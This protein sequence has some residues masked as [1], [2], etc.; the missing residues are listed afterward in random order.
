MRKPTQSDSARS[1]NPIPSP[2]SSVSHKTGASQA[3]AGSHT[4]NPHQ[5]IGNGGAQQPSKKIS[6][7]TSNVDKQREM[8]EKLQEDKIRTEM[9]LR[10]NATAMEDKIRSLAD[11]RK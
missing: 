1:L 6:Q 4:L 5:I 11:E 8:L 3:K 10:K 9:E 7:L 2:G